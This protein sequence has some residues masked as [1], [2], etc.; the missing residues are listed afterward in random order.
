ML[1]FYLFTY[2]FLSIPLVHLDLNPGCYVQTELN[3]MVQDK[4]KK[5]KTKQ[6]KQDLTYWFQ[7]VPLLQPGLPLLLS[8]KTVLLFV[9]ENK[10]EADQLSRGH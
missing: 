7:V 4:Q 10:M 2:L 9:V 8:W 1:V 3:R 6:Q 5:N